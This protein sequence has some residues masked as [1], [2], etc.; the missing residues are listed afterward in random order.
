MKYQVTT[1]VRKILAMTKRVRVVQGGSSAGKTIAILLIL[2]ERAQ[3][4][5]DKIFSIVSETLPHLKKGA[6]RDFLLIMEHQRYF[7]EANWNRTDFIYSFPGGSKIE[8]FSAD[9]ADKVRGPRRDVL[10][11]NEA[12]N[13]SFETYT[14]LTIR[15]N[16]CIYLDY[17]PVAEFWAHD[18][19]INKYDKITGKPSVEHDFVKL[20]YKDNEGLPEAIVKDLESRKDKKW[21]W[22]VYGLGE[23]GDAEGQIYNDWAQVDEIPHHARL[24]RRGLDFGYANDPTAVV[25]IYYYNGGYIVDEVLFQKGLSIKQ[26]ADTLNNQ[27]QPLILTVCDSADPR[28]IDELKSYG[29]NAVGVEKTRGETK[30]KPWVKWSIDLVAEQR[31]SVTKRSTNVWKAYKNY[32]WDRDKDDKILNVPDHKWSDLMDALR[33]GMV[34]LVKKPVVTMKASDPIAPYY[35]DRDLAF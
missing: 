23:V 20:T 8:F 21:W 12:N 2:I 10:F 25:D 29:V 11:I 33:Y 34:S 17:N 4:E 24:E 9:N 6:I 7:K 19:I 26:I 5:P 30:D 3:L 1:A 18:E 28:S 32:M 35:G 13:I 16:E 14:Q 27:Q 31:I 15:T 22:Q